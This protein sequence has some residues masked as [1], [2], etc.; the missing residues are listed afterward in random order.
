MSFSKTTRKWFSQK[1]LSHKNPNV[2]L[3]TVIR[4]FIQSERI[5]MSPKFFLTQVNGQ[6]ALAMNANL[7]LILQETMSIKR[8]KHTSGLGSMANIKY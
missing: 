6:L 7:M 5:R 4:L 2:K 8:R 1:V 3:I